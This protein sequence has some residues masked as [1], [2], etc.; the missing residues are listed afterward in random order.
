MF[1]NELLKEKVTL[2][3]GIEITLREATGEDED[4]MSKVANVKDGTSLPAYLSRVIV[5]PV[6][7]IEDIMFWPIA[8]K[9]YA[10]LKARMVSLGT[11]L[12][13]K[14]PFVNPKTNREEEVPVSV[15]LKAYDADLASYFKLTS[16]ESK[17]EFINSLGMDQIKPYPTLNKEQEFTMDGKKFK[18]DLLDSYGEQLSMKIED[19]E[20]SIN[21]ELRLRNLRIYHEDRWITIENF[22]SFTSRQ[23]SKIRT[24]MRNKEVKFNMDLMIKNP[25]NE[26]KPVVISLI[27]LPDFFYPV[28]H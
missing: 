24:E 2:P 4:L 27:A 20:L 16:K 12:D 10:M 3:H 25:F 8:S 5:D 1:T 22:S 13:F 28:G 15:D 26:R 21:D 9:Y 6:L 17:E 18:W 7:S 11:E 19:D 14:Y 23:M